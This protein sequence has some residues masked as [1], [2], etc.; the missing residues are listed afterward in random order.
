VVHKKSLWGNG[1]QKYAPQKKERDMAG[2][3]ISQNLNET[4]RSDF[5]AAKS[6]PRT[7]GSKLHSLQIW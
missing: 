6:H 3:F 5:P 7:S 4:L 1:N 2:D